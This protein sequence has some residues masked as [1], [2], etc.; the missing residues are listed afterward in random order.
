MSKIAQRTK[1]SVPF[2]FV[3]IIYIY[4]I[5]GY[6][7]NTPIIYGK[8]VINLQIIDIYEKIFIV[9][10]VFCCLLAIIHYK[11]KEY[12]FKI[13]YIV[14]YLFFFMISTYSWFNMWLTQDIVLSIILW[15]IG[16]TGTLYVYLRGR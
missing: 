13:D 12:S 8:Y 11:N 10:I 5:L 14:F 9:L 16:F 3:N 6:K 1:E 7:F 4:Y 15:F 2:F